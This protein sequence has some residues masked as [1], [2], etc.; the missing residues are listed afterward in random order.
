[1][2]TLTLTLLLIVS[3][4]LAYGQLE[5]WK[6]FTTS[7]EVTFVSTIKVKAN[8]MTRYLEG[9]QKTWV[10]AVE[11]QKEKGYITNWGLYISDLPASGD[12][13]LIT[14][15][16]FANDAATRGS[17]EIYDAITAY[18]RENAAPQAERDQIVQEDYPS[19]RTI[20]GGYRFRQVTFK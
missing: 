3:G 13:N 5:P 19:M 2:K 8:K 16:T 12:F 17:E 11:F 4:S 20:V 14:T 18:M 7:D 10:K 9:L 1:M 6:D 15:I